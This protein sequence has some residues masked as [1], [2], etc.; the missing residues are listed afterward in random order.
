MV[1]WGGLTRAG[2]VLSA[3]LDPEQTLDQLVRLAIPRVACFAMIDLASTGM[4]VERAGYEHIDE[5]RRPL[6]ERPEPFFPEEEGLVPL[7]QVLESGDAL[8]VQQV[9]RDWTGS[10]RILERIWSLDGRSLSLQDG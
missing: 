5:S 6:L 2:G 7:A 4:A 1:Y 10:E 9:E 8:L 3:S